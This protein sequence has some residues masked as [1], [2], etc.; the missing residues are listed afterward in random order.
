MKTRLPGDVLREFLGHRSVGMTDPYDNP[1]LFERL[2]AFQDM[3]SKVELFWGKADEKS[4]ENRVLEF[5]TS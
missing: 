5:K 3:R 1:I 4:E 2:L